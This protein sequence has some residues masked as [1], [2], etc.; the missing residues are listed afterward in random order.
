MIRTSACSPRAKRVGI[1]SGESPSDGPRVVTSVW[2]VAFSKAGPSSAYTLKNP[3]EIMTLMSA[4]DAVL[5]ASV[6]IRTASR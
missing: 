1:A 3:A 5:A 4:A 2:P 6:A